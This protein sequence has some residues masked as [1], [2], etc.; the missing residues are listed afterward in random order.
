[1]NSKIS[2]VKSNK[3]GQYNAWQEQLA[4]EA[5]R[6]A[7]RQA[8]NDYASYLSRLYGITGPFAPEYIIERYGTSENLTRYTNTVLPEGL[9][10]VGD[11]NRDG[12]SGY[13]GFSNSSIQFLG[14]ALTDYGI[15]N[16]SDL[17]SDG[18]S[19]TLR[20]LPGG[21]G[22]VLAA[23]TVGG[24]TFGI[25]TDNTLSRLAG[26]ASRSAPVIGGVIDFGI[27]IVTGE[28]VG[29][30]A[31]KATAH[32]AIGIGGGVAGAQIGAIVGS[33]VPVPVIGTAIGAGAGFLIG[34]GGSMLFD[35]IYDS[36]K[37]K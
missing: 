15:K 34:F 10:S 37:G 28:D 3:Q 18:L 21:R 14:R 12:L 20:N 25:V 32:T 33:F 13:S 16:S 30:A 22:S 9:P 7:Q 35:W 8:L 24:K 31:V 1:V 6:K 19:T 5:E 17:L 2:A 4:R 29:N 36:A 26:S 11:P 23:E 27:Q